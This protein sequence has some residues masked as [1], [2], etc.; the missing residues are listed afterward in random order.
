MVIMVVIGVA[1]IPVIEQMQGGQMYIYIQVISADLA[2]PI[3][4][5][6]LTAVLW[7]HANEQVCAWSLRV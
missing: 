6:Y 3:A 2:P 4:A 5:V 1:W 7:K